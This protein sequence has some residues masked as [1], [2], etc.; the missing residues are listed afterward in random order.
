ML[1]FPNTAVARFLSPHKDRD[2]CDIADMFCSM[3]AG[4]EHLRL[5]QE[6]ELPAV[7]G[8]RK[9]LVGGAV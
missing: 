1:H 8:Q 2:V 6:P 5:G 4:L 9:T 7:A 3:R